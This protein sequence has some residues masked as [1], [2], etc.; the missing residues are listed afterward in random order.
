MFAGDGVGAKYLSHRGSSGLAK[1]PLNKSDI[2]KG[3][4][5]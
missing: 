1:S 5:I 4:I 2:Y 3:D